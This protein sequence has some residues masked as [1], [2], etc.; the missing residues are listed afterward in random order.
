[1]SC[2]A[3]VVYMIT[4][5]C[6]PTMPGRSTSDFDSTRQRL[7]APS[8]KRAG[9]CWARRMKGELHPPKKFLGK[10]LDLGLGVGRGERQGREREGIECTTDTKKE[11]NRT[12]SNHEQNQEQ[13]QH[14][15]N[16][17]NR[18]TRYHNSYRAVKQR[19]REGG[20]PLFPVTTFTSTCRNNSYR[21]RTTF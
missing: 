10:G 8:A 7:L 9:R 1:M 20:S 18:K 13:Q 19:L 3:V 11:Q 16:K 6:I 21:Y 4:E 14:E 17:T 15:Q 12:G 5:P 2:M